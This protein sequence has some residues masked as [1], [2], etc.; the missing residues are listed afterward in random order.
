MEHDM[1]MPHIEYAGGAN[2]D[3]VNRSRAAAIARAPEWVRRGAVAVHG[4]QPTAPADPSARLPANTAAAR[5]WDG[6]GW[7]CGVCAPGVSTPAYG[8]TDKERLPEQFTPRCWE[9]LW[10]D[11]KAG[12]RKIALTWGHDG[13][14]LAETPIDLTFRLHSLFGMGLM[15]EARLRSDSVPAD[16]GKALEADGLGVSIGYTRPRQWITERSD[17]GRVRVVDDCE[18]DHVALVP[19]NRN[20]RAAYA[21]A[22]CYGLAGPRYGCPQAAIDRALQHAY[23]TLKRQAGC[24]E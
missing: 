21:G 3:L 12:K 4:R 18:L 16:V 5:R 10:G 6:W 1:T 22:R 11:I 2:L 19:Q 9:K 23:Q 15:F 8:T 7:V 20:Q 24:H 17:V 13:P 14:V